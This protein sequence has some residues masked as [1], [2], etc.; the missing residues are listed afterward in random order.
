MGKGIAEDEEAETVVVPDVGI[1][2]VGREDENEET[3]SDGKD[4]SLPMIWLLVSSVA[5]V[6]QSTAIG[7]DGGEEGDGGHVKSTSET[8]SSLKDTSYIDVVTAALD[9]RKPTDYPGAVRIKAWACVS[10]RKRL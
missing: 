5:Q 9:R 8:S 1:V 10:H 2:V 4:N 3:S 6:E 7:V